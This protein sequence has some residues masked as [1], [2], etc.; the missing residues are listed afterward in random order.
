MLWIVAQQV[1]LFMDFPRQE[2]QSDLLF[3]SPEDP[4]QPEIKFTFL[5]YPALQEDS[6]YLLSHQGSQNSS[7]T[8]L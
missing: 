5:V 1:P 4:P 6:F 8:E 3:S 7:S 2:Y